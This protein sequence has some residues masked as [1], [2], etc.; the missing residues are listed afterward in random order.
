MG[1]PRSSGRRALGDVKDATLDTVFEDMF[2]ISEPGKT[3]DYKTEYNFA[4]FTKAFKLMFGDFDFGAQVPDSSCPSTD[5][6]YTGHS[7][8]QQTTA[9]EEKIGTWSVHF[10]PKILRR[11]SMSRYDL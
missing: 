4:E 8:T 3:W 6:C 11:N 7:N 5:P 2:P 9:S 1:R 10:S